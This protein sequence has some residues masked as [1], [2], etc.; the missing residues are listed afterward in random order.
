MSLLA[1]LMGIEE[2][3]V[4]VH[5]FYAALKELHYGA[6]TRANIVSHFGLSTEDEVELDV[7][8]AKYQ[9]VGNNEK[10]EF[11]EFIHAVF[12]LAESGA[13]GYT[14]TAELNTR[15]QAF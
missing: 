9:S 11:V 12:M 15:I 6:V 7:L 8:I 1:K 14:T 2:P 5:Y 3:S 4:A 13:P 10:L